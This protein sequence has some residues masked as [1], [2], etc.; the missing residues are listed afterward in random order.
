MTGQSDFWKPAPF[1]FEA[2]VAEVDVSNLHPA[3]RRRAE[4]HGRMATR[5]KTEW[6]CMEP[7]HDRYDRSHFDKTSL[8]TAFDLWDNRRKGATQ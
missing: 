1:D 3:H 4:R 7:H 5:W 2:V 8:S 6:E